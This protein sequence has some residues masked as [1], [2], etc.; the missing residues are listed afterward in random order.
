GHQEDAEEFLGFYLDTLKE[1][2]LMLS[3]SLTNPNPAPAQQNNHVAA[4]NTQE[5]GWLEVGSVIAPS[6]RIPQKHPLPMI[7]I[8]GGKFR[9]TLRVPHQK[10]SVVVED[11]RSL[12]LDIQVLTSITR[13][14]ATLD[15]VQQIH[16]E[17]LPPTLILHLKRFLCDANKGGV[18]KVGKQVAFA[19]ELEVGSEVMVQGRKLRNG[20]RYW[21]FGGAF[22]S[23]SPLH[24]HIHPSFLFPCNTHSPHTTLY[25]HMVSQPQAD[26]IPSTSCTPTST[27]QI[28]PTKP[29]EG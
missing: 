7:R 16:V 28:P 1:E 22:V 2:L 27:C 24:L 3:S 12:Q 17:S 13:P 21:L 14:G 20:M 6:S 19:P 8:F 15:A 18:A 11:W 9:S 25:H 4:N 5:E 23:F 10:D 26:T 29:R